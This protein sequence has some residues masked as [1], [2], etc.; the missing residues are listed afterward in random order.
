MLTTYK[1]LTIYTNTGAKGANH[2]WTASA[3]HLGSLS[4]LSLQMFAPLSWAKFTSVMCAELDCS[5]FAHLPP[6][7]V[8]FSLATFPIQV[9]PLPFAELTCSILSVGQS[10]WAMLEAWRSRNAHGEISAAVTQ[11]QV[12]LRRRTNMS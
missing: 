4:Y 8:L 1:V 11:A 12:Q 7:H 2:E 5:S 3:D 6:T 9:Q 10:T